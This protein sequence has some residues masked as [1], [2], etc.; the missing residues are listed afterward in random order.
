LV[1][2]FV[3]DRWAGNGKIKWRVVLKVVAEKG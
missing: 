2:H 1:P 3:K